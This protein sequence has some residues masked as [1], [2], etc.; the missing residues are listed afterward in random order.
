MNDYA[1]LQSVKYQ[2]LHDDAVELAT[3][4]Y[5]MAK[6][7]LKYAYRSVPISPGDCPATGIS[8]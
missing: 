5:W 3:L 7:D 2:S 4:N 8:W 6:V 1:S